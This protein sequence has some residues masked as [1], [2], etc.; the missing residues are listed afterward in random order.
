MRE[1]KRTSWETRNDRDGCEV[2]LVDIELEIRMLVSALAYFST[3][4]VSDE[5]RD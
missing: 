2:Q 1:G 5:A 4:W 3:T